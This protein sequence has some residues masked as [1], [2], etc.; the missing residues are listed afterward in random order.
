VAGV[1]TRGEVT[2]AHRRAVLGVLCLALMMV[3]A[4]VASLNVALPELARDTGATQSQLQ[5]IVDAY[6]LVFAGL[7]LP[8]GALG[9][10]FGRKGI[11]LAGL[12]VFGGA[13]GAAMAVD[14]P[15]TLIGLRALIGVGAALVMPTTLSIITNIFPP[16]ERGRAV[17]IWAGVAGGGAMIGLLLSGTILEWFSWPAVFGIN[18]VLASLAFAT[19]IP[20][21]PTSRSSGRVRLDPVGAL[22]SSL[23]LFGLVFAIIEAP[24]W[25]WLDSLT[26]TAFG[27]GAL[28]L[29]AFVLFE[30][31][32]REPMLDA[33]LFARRGFGVGSL[34]LTLQFFAQ[35][36]FLFIALQYLQFVLGYSPLQAGLSIFPMGLMLMAISPRAP[37]L[38]RRL[39][40]RIVGGAGLALMGAGFLIFTTLDADSSYWHFGGGAVVTGIGLA[41]A[42]APAT[43]AI[44]SSL[45]AHKQGIAS[46]VNDLAREVGGAFGI[47]VLGS[48]LNSAY[49]DDIAS[50]TAK[51]PEPASDAAR[52]SIAAATEIAQ[53]A[54][55]RGAPLLERAEDA[56]VNG[57][58]ASLFVGALVLFAASALVALL[59]PRREEGADADAADVDAAPD[60]RPEPSPVGQ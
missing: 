27:A 41:L 25:G 11:L 26:L 22:L 4:A 35:F 36:G 44:V 9:D 58:S 34:S 2:R 30:L 13:S 21:V 47:A 20:I 55:A 48:V 46:A 3:V 5:W 1:E 10:R 32:R 28:L 45:P 50:A 59:A 23:G 57:L 16:E 49:R 17:G 7:L 56:F 39:G 12:V 51:L 43:T 33:R 42:T 6:A 54:G 40:V 8:A 15:S 24:Q 29:V 18:V 14:D 60:L 53:H 52:N 38:A 31:V 37:K 19:T